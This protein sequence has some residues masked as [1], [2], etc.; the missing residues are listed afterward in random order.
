MIGSTPP[1]SRPSICARPR[2][3]IAAGSNAKA[4]SPITASAP[5]TG[6]S[7]TGRQSTLMP[8]LG[9]VVRDQPRVEIDRLQRRLVLRGVD[10]AEARRRRARLPAGRFQ[11]R[12]ASAFLVDQDG[13]A[14]VADRLAQRRR[15]A[16]GSAS[17]SWMLRANRMKPQGCTSRK[18]VALRPR[19]A[20]CRRSHRSRACASPLP[21]PVRPLSLRRDAGAAFGLQLVAQRGGRACAARG[22]PRAGTRFP[23]RPDR[24]A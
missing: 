22:D 11:P 24:P 7:S 8:D 10:G 1:S 12:H 23:W 9:Q 21:L 6:T 17:R 13:R 16:R 2:S 3:M 15:P 20:R 18:N 4:R 14:V 19:P 5:S